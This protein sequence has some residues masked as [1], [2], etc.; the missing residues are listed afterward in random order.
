M[1][2]RLSWVSVGVGLLVA[3]LF[4]IPTASRVDVQE[5]ALA[6]GTVEKQLVTKYISLGSVLIGHFFRGTSRLDR[7]SIALGVMIAAACALLVE[8]GVRGLRRLPATAR[9]LPDGR[10]RR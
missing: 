10:G 3:A 7:V 4:L 6:N 9:G 2:F 1:R 8:L 5:V